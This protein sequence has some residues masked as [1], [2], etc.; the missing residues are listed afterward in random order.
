MIRVIIILFVNVG[1]IRIQL[2]NFIILST[3]IASLIIFIIK[4]DKLTPIYLIFRAQINRII[5]LYLL[6]FIDLQFSF[7]EDC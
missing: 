3:L 6:G 5:L 2:L 4:S 1:R 7:L